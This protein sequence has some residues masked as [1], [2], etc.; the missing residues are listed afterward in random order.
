MI[1]GKISFWHADADPADARELLNSDIQADVAIIGAGYTGLWAAYYLKKADPKLEICILEAETVGF[2]ASGRNG[3][4]ISY[5]MPGLYSRYAKTHGE[6]AV[7]AFQQAVFQ[8][9]SEIVRICEEEGIQA[10]IAY[11]GE[12]AIA[13]NRA[14]MERLRSEFKESSRWG[15]EQGDLELIAKSDVHDFARLD[16]AEGGLYSPHGARV[17]PAKLVRGL[18]AVVEKLGV[19]IYERTL[20]TSIFPR[21]VVTSTGNQ[22]SAKHIIKGTEGYSNSIKGFKR[23]W[24]PKLSSMIVT[25]PLSQ[26]VI[27]QIGWNSN[28][29]VRDSAHFFSYIQKTADNRIAL[30]GPGVPYLFG[31][32]WDTNGETMRRS[33]EALKHRVHK[34]FPMLYDT[35]FSH[36]WTG[37]LGI[38]RNWSGIVSYDEE[39]GLG[40]AGG[41]VGDG[42]SSSNL[43]ARTLRDLILKR[44]TPLTKLPWVG[45]KIKKWEFEPLRWIALRGMYQVYTLADHLEDR[46]MQ[47]KTSWVARAANVVTGRR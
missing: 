33:V 42:V 43:A 27:E 10:D 16:Q 21:R 35:E 5:G 20:V 41:Y 36:V 31:S 13:T 12:I 30:G 37:V 4:W 11:E 38:P 39:S 1:N 28:V 15:F 14:Q 2:G 8:S 34:R 23:D 9:V 44:D 17:Q 18:A 46:S 7:G 26:S 25:E 32:R 19:K 40:I 6:R 29:L 47:S 3:G 22:I 45:G 24:L